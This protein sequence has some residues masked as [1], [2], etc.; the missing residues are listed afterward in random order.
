MK[1]AVVHDFTHP[2]SIDN[3]PTP[4]PSN[5]GGYQRG[6]PLRG[7]VARFRLRALPLLQLGS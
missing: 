2:L 5:G 4:E 1:A 6:R 3:V 7:P